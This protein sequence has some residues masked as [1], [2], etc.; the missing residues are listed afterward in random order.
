MS[1]SSDS[2]IRFGDSPQI[3]KCSEDRRRYNYVNWF[4]HHS[5]IVLSTLHHI[6]SVHAGQ[7]SFYIIVFSIYFMLR[8]IGDLL[9]V[10][11]AHQE[12]RNSCWLTSLKR[13]TGSHFHD[14]AHLGKRRLKQLGR[15]QFVNFPCTAS[16]DWPH[17]YNNYFINGSRWRM[18]FGTSLLLWRAH[19]NMA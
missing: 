15:N 5:I 4:C 19:F 11:T 3:L 17:C 6:L 1:F 10:T 2:I 8:L 7:Y 16:N 12:L 13:L 14:P 9:K 18:V